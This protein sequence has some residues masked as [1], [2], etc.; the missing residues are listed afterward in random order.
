MSLYWATL[1]HNLLDPT[2]WSRADP[3]LRLADGTGYIDHL[4]TAPKAGARLPV[5]VQLVPNR[6]RPSPSGMHVPDAFPAMAGWFTASVT[7]SALQSLL[8]DAAVQRVVW[9]E[10]LLPQRPRSQYAMPWPGTATVPP[11]PPAGR[12]TDVLLGVIDAGCPFAHAGLRRADGKS[13]RVVR[14]WDQQGGLAAPPPAWGYGSEWS[15][16]A[17]SAVMAAATDAN[18][19][20]DEHLCYM[21]AGADQLL[22]RTSHGAHALGLLAAPW[23]VDGRPWR[24]TAPPAR[25]LQDAAATADIAFVQ[26]PRKLLDSA[27]PPAVEHHVLNGLR[28]LLDVAVQRGAIHLCVSF[29]FESWLGPHDGSTWFSQAVDDL[30]REA[31][32]T[33]GLTLS[34][35]VIAGNAGDDGVHRAVDSV[36]ADAPGT[37]HVATVHWHQPPGD[38][39]VTLLELWLPD[40]AAPP[41][42][43]LVVT[44]PGN[45]GSLPPVHWGDAVAWPSAAAPAVS[46]VMDNSRTQGLHAD[47]VVLRITHTQTVAPRRAAPH[48]EWCLSLHSAQPLQGLHAYIGRCTE[49]MNSPPRGRQAAFTRRT[50]AQRLLDRAGTLSGFANHAGARVATACVSAR[51][52]YRGPQAAAQP[53]DATPYAGIGPSRDG[54][55][56]GP[57]F[58]VVVEHGLYHQGLLGI[59]NRSGTVFRM[60]GTSVAAPIGARD[61]AM[62]GPV[63]TPP[64]PPEIPAPQLQTV[65]VTILDPLP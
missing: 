46:V 2:F 59:G 65:G 56:P 12:G 23:L 16:D 6:P 45:I 64:P 61:A 29:A 41:D 44:P 49:S 32:Q 43:A 17:L 63:G 51:T 31:T 53:G 33:H 9:A 10:G 57:S 13:T 39:T 11:P 19:R 3:Y 40:G 7:P 62:S 55:R 58:G 25:L 22:G 28:Y 18:G 8:T 34:C 30:V 15:G 47:A 42:L 35:T 50:P 1:A 36:P 54:L 5:S 38:E 24:G 20:V 48:G 37:G 26:L 60:V 21:R 4:P 27:F 52:V 14:L